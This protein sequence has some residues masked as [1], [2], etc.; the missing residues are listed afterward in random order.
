MFRCIT[1][2]KGLAVDIDSFPSLKIEDW[3]EINEIVPCVFL[4]TDDDKKSSLSIIFGADKVVRMVKFERYFAPSKNTHIKVLKAL[5]VKNTELAYLSCRHSFLENANG[6]L[7]GTIWISDHVT[8]P[9]GK[10]HGFNRGM[11][12]DNWL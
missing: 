7:S 4:T 3:V 1:E 9:A 8:K 2:L 6:F 12:G 5:D 10:A 11:R